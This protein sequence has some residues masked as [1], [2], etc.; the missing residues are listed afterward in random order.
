VAPLGVIEPAFEADPDTG[1][2]RR[3]DL[4]PTPLVA[5]NVSKRPPSTTT[6]AASVQRAR[7]GRAS[8]RVRYPN[9]LGGAPR[10]AGIAALGVALYRYRCARQ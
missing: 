7:P 4:S 9:S 5:V 6:V 10:G 8:Y 2:V 1:E 3:P